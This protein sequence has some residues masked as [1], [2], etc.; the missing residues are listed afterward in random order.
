MEMRRA[1]VVY[2]SLFGGTER[3]ARA[4]ATGL[5]RS[6]DVRVGSVEQLP[7]SDVAHAELL[8]LGGPTHAH[9]M[10]LPTTRA[11][12]IAWTHDVARQLELAPGTHSLGVREWLDDLTAVP[13]FAAFDTRASIPRLLSG[14]A[15]HAIARALAKRDGVAIA[16]P[17]SFLVDSANA[18][19]DGEVQRAIAWGDALAATLLSR[20]P[21]G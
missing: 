1:L 8:V 21:V 15:S 19:A 2:E 5:E 20:T 4:I 14:A 9:S 17:E 18:L 6:L 11:E 3:I 16:E 12:A 13:L 7:A 10:S